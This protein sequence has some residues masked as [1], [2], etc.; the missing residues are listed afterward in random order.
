MD[1]QQ[2]LDSS[3]FFFLL[4]NSVLK[5]DFVSVIDVFKIIILGGRLE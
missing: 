4:I 2:K 1:P 5:V 3:N